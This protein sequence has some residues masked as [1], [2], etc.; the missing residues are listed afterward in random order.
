MNIIYKKRG[1]FGSYSTV[2]RQGFLIV[3]LIKSEARP[4]SF[5]LSEIK[6]SLDSMNLQYSLSNS[7]KKG[8][9]FML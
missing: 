5:W 6:Q 8:G 9:S 1:H 3:T 2:N 7:G 4:L